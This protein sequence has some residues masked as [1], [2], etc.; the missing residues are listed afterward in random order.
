MPSTATTHTRTH[1]LYLQLFI[2]YVMSFG[3]APQHTG[4]S[5]RRETYRVE[6]GP[7]VYFFFCALSNAS[8]HGRKVLR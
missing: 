3:A 7:T 8:R 2:K 1:T 4:E 6:L 5:G